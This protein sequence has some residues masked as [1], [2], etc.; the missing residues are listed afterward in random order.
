MEEG[1]N[2]LWIL[3]LNRRGV[4][5]VWIYVG[6]SVYGMHPL[7]TATGATSMTMP[8]RILIVCA[9]IAFLCAI[10]AVTYGCAQ[11]PSGEHLAEILNGKQ[12]DEFYKEGK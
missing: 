3:G 6:R 1:L 10:A 2:F 11:R 4:G 9:V 5:Y 7:A 12:V 8:V